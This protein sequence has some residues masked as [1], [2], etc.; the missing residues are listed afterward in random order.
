MK[1]CPFCAEQ[2]Q[3][4]AIKCRYC[5]EDLRTKEPP[6]PLPG[7]DTSPPLPASNG[8]PSGNI[9]GANGYLWVIGA[10]LFFALVWI[11][12]GPPKASGPPKITAPVRPTETEIKL[13][14]YG[15]CKTDFKICKGKFIKFE[16]IVKS[17]GDQY[18]RIATE[19]HGFDVF[20]L[21][22]VDAQIIGSKVVFSG[23]LAEDHTFND[24]VKSGAIE[25]IL[26]SAAEVK[27]YEDAHPTCEKNWKVCADNSDLIEHNTAWMFHGVAACKL[28]V[29][30]KAKYGDLNGPGFHSANTG[31]ATITL[32][33]ELLRS[34]MKMFVFK[35]DLVHMGAPVSSASTT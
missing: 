29:D 2:I 28:A 14:D 4:A 32:R 21:G 33:L 34:P 10:A 19:V 18:L 9:G 11:I 35:M 16:G 26:M 30:E 17:K 24:D 15:R 13:A 31:Q 23:Y 7:R 22:S 8:A 25:Y 1:A 3:D 12:S 27:A 5:G 6:P 20:G